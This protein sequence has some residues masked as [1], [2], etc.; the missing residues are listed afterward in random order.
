V[1]YRTLAPAGVS[2]F[3][4]TA[5]FAVAMSITAFPVLAR[6]IS[7]RGLE[8]TPL[9]VLALTCAAVDDV[10][11]WCLL[12]LVAG[13]AASSPGKGFTTVGLLL[14]YVAS[15]LGIV[16][17]VVRR[18]TDRQEKL[19]RVSHGALL[20]MLLLLPLS[21]FATESIGVHALFGSF[22]LGALVNAESRLAHGISRIFETVVRVLLLPVFFAFAGLR[23]QLALVSGG[24]AW[25]FFAL[26]I[27]VA[28]LGKLGGI[29][30]AARLSGLEWRRSAALG[31]LMNTR[32][33][34][35]L[36][37]LNMG[38]DLGIISPALFAMMVMM[39]LVT[40]LAAAPLL[41]WLG[42]TESLSD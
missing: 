22:L 29:T 41:A 36:V 18:I 21:A 13:V 11:A 23:T 2:G 30:L 1:L 24:Q 20:G 7:E 17:P 27:A 4:F 5:F 12:A 6:I 9:G 15:M 8:R 35:E 14:V 10:S 3:L 25:C 34:M 42:P 40:T 28:F 37:V 19:G 26:I 32:G 39:A 31:A 16:R 33:L 38:L